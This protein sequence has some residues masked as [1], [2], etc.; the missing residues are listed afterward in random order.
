MVVVRQVQVGDL[1]DLL[2]LAEMTGFGL[3]T[4]PRDRKLLERRIRMAK[5]A[6][7][8]SPDD[9]PRGEAFLFVMEDTDSGKVIGT[10][11]MVSKVG[12][13]EPFYAYRIDT[14]VHSSAQLRVHKEIRVLN[15]VTEHNGPCEIG[16][17]FLSP[18]HRRH[19]SGRLLSL[20]RFLFMAEY[21]QYFDPTVI[22]EMR[23]VI[24]E[25][26][27]SDFWDA[28]GRHFFDVDFPTADY[29]SMVDKQFIA[30]LMP[31]HPIYIPLL[32][33]AAQGVIGEVHEQT[34]PARRVL[35]SEGFEFSGMVDIFEAGPILRCSLG[36]IRAVRQSVAGKVTDI[37][38]GEI[39]S[40][41]Y[42]I[43]QSAGGFRACLGRVTYNTDDNGKAANL[44]I[45]RKA[46][47]L[48]GVS[49]GDAVR[50]VKLKAEK[51]ANG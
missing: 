44:A 13:F 5:L 12:G 48:L 38:A 34:R 30:D 4:L 41:D 43:S 50:F 33:E 8:R 21:P 19:G 49:K 14:V 45:E 29:L 15:L 20:A 35:E 40:D 10:S 3:T 26:G 17:L 24:D 7:E 42:A 32:P 27:Q 47:D 36:K 51:P 46:A 9:P 28:L 16:S 39:A 25:R 23:G 2:Q 6:F 1:D 18:D 22:A 11:G 37:V 31:R